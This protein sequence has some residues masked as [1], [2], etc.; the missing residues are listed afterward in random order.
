MERTDLE[1]NVCEVDLDHDGIMEVITRTLDIGE[2]CSRYFI[3]HVYHCD[4]MGE[5]TELPDML[6]YSPPSSLA[7]HYWEENE[8]II[9][10]ETMGSLD[11]EVLSYYNWILQSEYHSYEDM[12]YLPILSFK[13]LD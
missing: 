11:F 4:E 3:Y 12:S 13:P 9:I 6:F 1:I 8:R 5:Y 10:D 7:V 2:G